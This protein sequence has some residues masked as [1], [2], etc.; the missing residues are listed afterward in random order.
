VSAGMSLILPSEAESSRTAI[1]VAV[2]LTATATTTLFDLI[3]IEFF[4]QLLF[5]LYASPVE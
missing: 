1:T 2:Y 4:Q 3:L 5:F